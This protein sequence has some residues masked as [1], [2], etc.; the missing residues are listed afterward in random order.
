MTKRNGKA[1]LDVSDLGVSAKDRKGRLT[2]IVE[3]VSFSIQSGKVIALIGE[4]GSGKTTISL[5]CMGYA[6]AGCEITGGVIRL[7]DADVLNLPFSRR[8][9][10]RGRDI[11]YIA[12]SAAAAFNSALPRNKQVTETPGIKILLSEGEATAKAVGLYRELDLPDPETIGNRYPHQVSGGQLQRL[13]AA[14][15]MI[16]DPKLL[17]LDEPTTALDVTTQIEVLRAFKKLIH[18]RNTSAIYVSHDLAVVAQMSDDILVLKDGQPVEYGSAEQIIHD[19]QHEYTRMLVAA[20]HVMPQ[21]LP[22]STRPCSNDIGAPLLEVKD[23]TAGYGR[24]HEHIALRGV[25]INAYESR[26]VGIIGES[27]SGKTTLGRV[28]AGLM[29]PQSG[30]VRLSGKALGPETN[31]RTR[32]ELRSIQFAFQMADVALNPRHRVRKILGRPLRFY[33]GM[34]DSDVSRRVA[35]LLELVEMP[36]SYASRFPRELSGGQRQRVNLAR[37]LAAEPKLIICDEI[38]S[39][40]DTIVAQAILD[41]LRHLQEQ[42]KLAYIFISHDLSTI[43]QV[44][45]T[46]CV[47]RSAEIVESGQTADILTPPHHDYTQ[48]LLSSV[49]ELRTDWLDMCR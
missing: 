34:S 22:S 28:I 39:A 32:D 41:L 37:A 13:M 15:A 16:C 33:F 17:I 14:M 36:A 45:D 35:E 10:I 40:L 9:A 11:S 3:N 4:S 48:L 38:T 25:S 1:V 31:D 23:V 12:Q 24:N 27:G 18:D 19:P 7:G 30:A 5:A 26:T 49:P 43:A 21:V 46:I 42:L 8:R 47:M 20:A 6:R 29:A 2:K 44:S